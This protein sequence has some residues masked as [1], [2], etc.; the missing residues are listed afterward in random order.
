MLTAPKVLLLTVF[1]FAGLL[2]GCGGD[3]DADGGEAT[4]SQTPTAS[5]LTNTP[6]ST[7]DDE[8]TPVPEES[9]DGGEEAPRD[10]FTPPPTA[11]TGTRATR[12]DDV[13]AFFAQSST[14]PQ[15]ERQCA[16]NPSTRVI[17]C[18]DRGLYAPDPP[19]L[20][21]GIECYLMASGG[22][23]VVV[24]C[25]IAEPQGAAYYDVRG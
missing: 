20:G 10:T 9:P 11:T 19:P 21:Q 8:K 7:G 23:A 3:E 1:L 13:S 4:P 12:I 16:Y 15:D 18:S 6:E 25:E 2:A 24:R 14:P 22:N 17:D 5:R